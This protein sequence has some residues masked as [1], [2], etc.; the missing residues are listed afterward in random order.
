[1]KNKN[2][3]NALTELYESLEPIEK[4]RVDEGAWESIK[5]GLSKLGRYKAG[6][7]ILGKNKT[8]KAAER[9]IRDILNK[10]RPY[11]HKWEEKNSLNTVDFIDCRHNFIS[12]EFK[13]TEKTDWC[14]F[15][16]I[17]R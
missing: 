8:T 4:E 7:K 9:K 17:I 5:Y 1:M 15:K 10:E 12:N 13:E 11:I 6:G 16:R 3:D 14:R 2:Y